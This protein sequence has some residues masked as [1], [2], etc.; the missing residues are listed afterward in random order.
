LHF[1]ALDRHCLDGRA[2]VRIHV[3]VHI[4]IYM[5]ISYTCMC[6]GYSYRTQHGQCCLQLKNK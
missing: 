2:Q 1:H 6:A 4:Y 5:Y 3:C